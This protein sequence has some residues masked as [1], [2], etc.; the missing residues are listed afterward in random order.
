MA[1]GIG[2]NTGVAR[3]GNTGSRH[4][5]KYGPLGNTVN[6]ASRVQGA[7]KHLKCGLLITG[8]TAAKL[9]ETFA[10][11][12]LCRVQ[13]INIAAAVELYELA[14]PDRPGWVTAQAEY[15]QALAEFEGSKFGES[16]W[17]LADLLRQ[18]RGDGPA[19]VLLARAVN[20]LA[21]GAPPMHPVWVLPTK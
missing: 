14:L 6:L 16:A 18:L 11:R 1:F 10:R 20:A 9:D 17:R 4:K 7:T 3:V 13:V 5:F 8:A 12:R 19:L 2:V 21:E 15:E